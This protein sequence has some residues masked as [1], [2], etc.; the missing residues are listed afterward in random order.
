MGPCLGQV[1]LAAPP[2]HAPIH[3]PWALF[4]LGQYKLFSTPC[5]CEGQEVGGRAHEVVRAK[6]HL[7]VLSG[8]APSPR[9]LRTRPSTPPSAAF[10]SWSIRVLLPVV[11]VRGA[12]GGRGRA[13]E[14]V[15]A[16]AHL[17]VLSGKVPSPRRLR[18]HPRARQQCLDGQLCSPSIRPCTCV[19][20]ACMMHGGAVWLRTS[21]L[22]QHQARACGRSPKRML[23]GC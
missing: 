20:R 4:S 13:H 11:L 23:L 17:H 5:A 16:K 9:R 10:L 12:G 3:A 15:R 1:S 19:A 18:M 8:N 14:G 21:S 6:A 7:H 2:A 22:K